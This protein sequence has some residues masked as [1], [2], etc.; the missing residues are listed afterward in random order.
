MGQVKRDAKP[1][2]KSC[3][4]PCI[5]CADSAGSWP[6]TPVAPP[7]TTTLGTVKLDRRCAPTVL[8]V[9]EGLQQ[10]PGQRVLELESPR[11]R[12][13]MEQPAGEER[14]DDLVLDGRVRPQ[15]KQGLAQQVAD[16]LG[17]GHPEVHA[18]LQPVS[19]A[20]HRREAQKPVHQVLKLAHL[21]L[22]GSVV[23]VAHEHFAPLLLQVLRLLLQR[24]LEREVLVVNGADGAC[25]NLVHGGEVQGGLQLAVRPH[26]PREQ[27]QVAAADPEQGARNAVAVLDVLL[28]HGA[29]HCGFHLGDVEA[30]Q[31]RRVDRGLG[32]GRCRAPHGDAVEGS[33]EP[34]VEE[35]ER[36]GAVIGDQDGGEVVG[37]Q[38]REQ[39]AEEAPASAPQK[40]RARELVDA[41]EAQD[42]P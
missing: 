10:K 15:L 13:Q 6:C 27:L 26:E 2:A 28:E 1:T 23:D 22:Q 31:R 8:F 24:A 18:V 34:R 14:K 4:L 21:A 5:L 39:L 40:G 11:L 29:R 19:N 20:F 17:N 16:R 38:G 35:R 41:V 7:K 42:P 33:R 9:D 32:G 37:L 12:V 3:R 25:Q 30:E 36:G